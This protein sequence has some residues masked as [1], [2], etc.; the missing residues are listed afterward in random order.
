MDDYRNAL[1]RLLS[2]DGALAEIGAATLVDLG[3]RLAAPSEC[4]VSG[5]LTN[6]ILA[7]LGVK[8]PMDVD[9]ASFNQAAEQ[10][11]RGRLRQQYLKEGLDAAGWSFR[12]MDQQMSHDPALRC[13]LATLT[14]GRGAGDFLGTAARDV[15]AGKA[16]PDTLR[17]LIGLLLLNVEREERRYAGTI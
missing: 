14:D 11:Y 3:T 13:A 6:A 15:R 1:Q 4:G 5:R 7:D 17:R 9:A 2:E 16:A 8:S 12:Q 10:H